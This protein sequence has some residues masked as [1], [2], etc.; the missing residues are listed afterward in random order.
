MPLYDGHQSA[1][2]GLEFHLFAHFSPDC[3]TRGSVPVLVYVGSV[4]QVGLSVSTSD[5]GETRPCGS[6]N[7]DRLLWRKLIEPPIYDFWITLSIVVEQG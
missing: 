2:K 7:T 5:I 3:P 4:F 6:H 1:I